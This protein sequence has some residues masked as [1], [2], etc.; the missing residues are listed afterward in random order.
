MNNAKIS[1]E[2]TVSLES[3]SIKLIV[4]HPD[5]GSVVIITQ[6]WDEEDKRW[7]EHKLTI[8]PAQLYQIIKHLGLGIVSI[9]RF[10]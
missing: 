4:G 6:S 2:N 9:E 3:G 10:R 5:D 8:S 1:R 7:T